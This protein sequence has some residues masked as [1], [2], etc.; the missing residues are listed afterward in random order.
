MSIS[1][2]SLS[3]NNGA[4]SILTALGEEIAAKYQAGEPVDVE[5]CLREHPEQ[6]E[7]LRALLPTVQVL[8][9]LGRSAAAGEASVP[10]TEADLGPE[11]K[12]LG[13]FR[14][15]REIGRGGM[16]IVYEAE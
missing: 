4:D 3:L 16:G 15:V 14:I 13:D 9:D 2:Q 1:T 12:V 11:H 5:A 10:P 6:A 7:R 8:A